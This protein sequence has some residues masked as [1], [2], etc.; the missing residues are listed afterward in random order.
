MASPGP[1]NLETTYL[2]LRADN[3][4]EPLPV[5]AEFWPK[6]MSGRLGT[7]HRESLVTMISFDS[8]W[9]NWEMHPN[10]D[11]IVCLVSGKVS[12]VLE[13]DG[14]EVVA[15]LMSPGDY[16]LVPKGTW[17]TART[18]EKCT[19]LFVTP[20]EGTQNRPG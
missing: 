10:G 2:R 20:G 6:L 5:N 3:S 12:M 17:H 9:N 8:T 15:K 13:L 1:F 16:V 19:M 18:N 14:R 11:E 4:A 7:F